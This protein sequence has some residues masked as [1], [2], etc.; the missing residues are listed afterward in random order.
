MEQFADIYFAEPPPPPDFEPLPTI[1]ETEPDSN[2]V[3]PLFYG[4]VAYF[5]DIEQALEDSMMFFED[6]AAA[7]KADLEDAKRELNDTKKEAGIIDDRK[8]VTST[9]H[10]IQR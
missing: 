3:N 4:V 10:F 2:Q 1:E 6:E 9:D 8:P 5:A 7:K